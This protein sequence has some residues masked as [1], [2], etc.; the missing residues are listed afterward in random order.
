MTVLAS[1][2]ICMVSSPNGVQN[3]LEDALLACITG[4]LGFDASLTNGKA[5]LVQTDWFCD[6]GKKI[7]AFSTTEA[8]FMVILVA[9][10]DVAFV[11]DFV[12]SGAARR[13]VARLTKELIVI[14]CRVVRVD[15]LIALPTAIAFLVE[16]TIFILISVSM[17]NWVAAASTLGV[18]RAKVL[19]FDNYEASRLERLHATRHLACKAFLMPHLTLSL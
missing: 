5:F 13:G 11:Q 4:K 7:T 9:H 15:R 3:L 16:D 1:K 10:G 17:S 19:S 18:V 8:L 2:T 14:E 6:G 12:A